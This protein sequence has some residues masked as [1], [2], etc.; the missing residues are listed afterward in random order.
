MPVITV[1]VF[2]M[3]AVH[4]NFMTMVSWGR[5]RVWLLH[6]VRR[7]ALASCANA[8]ILNTRRVHCCRPARHPSL[9]QRRYVVYQPAEQMSDEERLEMKRRVQLA[10]RQQ[11]EEQLAAASGAQQQEPGAPARALK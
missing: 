7:V 10:R 8:P 9:V 4:E 3:P 5:A 1:L 6:T 2:S 11:R